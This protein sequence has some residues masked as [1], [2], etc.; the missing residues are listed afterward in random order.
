[1][2]LAYFPEFR[3]CSDIPPLH[4]SGSKND[5]ENYRCIANLSSIHKLFKKIIASQL[6]FSLPQVIKPNQHGF[7]KGR[8]QFK[9]TFLNLRLK[10]MMLLE[11]VIYTD[12]CKSA[13]VEKFNLNWFSYKF[14]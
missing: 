5:V 9:P 10:L 3:K 13:Y 12:F 6:L 7:V 14:C 8:A 2:K 11:M 4:K 1:M